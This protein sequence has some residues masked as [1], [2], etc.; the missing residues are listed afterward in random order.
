MAGCAEI[1]R[2]FQD[3]KDAETAGAV[4]SAGTIEELAVACELPQ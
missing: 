4:R 1:A 2:Q 3:F